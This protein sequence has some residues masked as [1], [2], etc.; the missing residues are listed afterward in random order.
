MK[1]RYKVL[2]AEHENSQYSRMQLILAEL[3]AALA[4]AN[5]G[6]EVILKTLEF[7]PDIIFLDADIP[8]IN[9]YEACRM[10]KHHPD[11]RHIP[12]LMIS[13]GND[14]VAQC[15]SIEAGASDCVLKPLEKFEV[16][17]RTKNLLR[18]K[19]Y[20]DFLKEH[21]HCL[22]RETK[23]KAA[24]LKAELRDSVRAQRSL[25]DSYLDTI[26]RLTL[27]AEYRDEAAASHLHRVGKTCAI[28]A[29]ALGWSDDNLEILQYASLMHDIGKIAI[30]ADILMKPLP[31]TREEFALMKTHTRIGAEILHGSDSVYLQKAEIIAANHH[32]HWDG[33]GYP[34]GK[35]GEE[36]PIEARIMALAD[37][38]DALRTARP[39][40][41]AF[42]YIH[43]YRVIVEGNERIKPEHFDPTL[44]ELF[45]DQH[46][47]FENLY[48][49][50]EEVNFFDAAVGR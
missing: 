12:V 39:Y 48:N 22:Y 15:R 25:K 6:K 24:E 16:I 19:E 36:I 43:A 4:R 2:I 5:S 49:T 8:G 41:P 9:G 20:D 40:K 18:I 30:P 50:F 31:L 45:R 44:L 28:I 10:L 3:T 37:K 46:R 27:V 47:E 21:S 26:Y 7:R 11:T 32:E 14:R 17:T 1:N 29:A 33:T 35:T 38:Y 13:C 34:A 23:K 42:D